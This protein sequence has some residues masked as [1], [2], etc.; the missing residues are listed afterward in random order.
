MW[1]LIYFSTFSTFVQYLVFK[2]ALATMVSTIV[3]ASIVV[4]RRVVKK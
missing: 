4:V 1:N 3:G 2:H